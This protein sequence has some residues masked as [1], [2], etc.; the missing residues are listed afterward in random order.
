MTA[1]T[2]RH[3]QGRRLARISLAAP[4]IAIGLAGCGPAAAPVRGVQVRLEETERGPRASQQ[5]YPC[6]AGA[7]YLGQDVLIDDRD[8]VGASFLEQGESRALIR[9]ELTREGIRKLG[10]VTESNQAGR[11]MAFVRDGKVLVT[12]PFGLDEKERVLV[13][14]DLPSLRQIY[15]QLTAPEREPQPAPSP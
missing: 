11:R 3:R 9:I 1:T 15:Q 13:P 12:A 4:C 6:P 10:L 14:G 8:I 7:C 2:T 5:P